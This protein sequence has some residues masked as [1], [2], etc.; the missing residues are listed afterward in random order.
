MKPFLWFLLG[1]VVGFAVARRSRS[2]SGS[3][4]GVFARLDDTVRGFGAAVADGYRT[5]EAE[6]RAAIDG[7]AD[8]V[9]DL[10]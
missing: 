2:R 4:S 7:A 10:S 1:A 6:L 8:T 5:R 9:A 3:D